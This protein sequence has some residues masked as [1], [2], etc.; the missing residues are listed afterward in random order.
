VTARPVHLPLFEVPAGARGTGGAVAT[1]AAALP[2]GVR[3]RIA[4]VQAID[5]TAITLVL[6]NGRT[7]AWGS[8]ARSTDKA[9]VL[10]TLLGQ[11]GDHFDVSNPDQPFVR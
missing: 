10:P 4:S 9:R 7:V 11:P 2:P 1:V 8:A 3:A 6:Q 5:P